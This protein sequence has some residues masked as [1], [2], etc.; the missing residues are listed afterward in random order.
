[1]VGMQRAPLLGDPFRGAPVL[2]RRMLAAID[3]IAAI[4]A[5]AIEHVPRL[6]ADAPVKDASVAFA[7]AMVLGC[8]G[9]RDALAA[10]EL[11]LLRSGKRQGVH[12]RA[13]RCLEAGP[14]R[15]LP[16]ALCSLL[17]EPEPLVRAMT[18]DVLAY[19]GFATEDELA[20]AASDDVPPWR[21]ARSTTSAARRAPACPS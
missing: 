15:A 14:A 16:L 18:I 5:L 17:R 6:V 12:R 21:R 11:A 7:S 19:R 2:E 3:V 9:G 1:M 8:F 4:G 13:G 20:A 10:A